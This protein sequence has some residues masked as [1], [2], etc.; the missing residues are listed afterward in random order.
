[1]ETKQRG[2]MF[3]RRRNVPKAR[4]QTGPQTAFLKSKA[5]LTIYGGAAGGGKTYALLMEPLKH[6]HNPDFGAVVFR[7]TYPQIMEEGGLWDEATGMYPAEGATPLKGSV[8]WKFPTGATIRFRHIQYDKDVNTYQGAQI[9]LML[10]DQLEQ[11]S[12][13]QFFAMAAR[14]RSM[15]GV[16]SYQRATCNPQPGW[17]A[18]FVDWWIGDDGYARA[19]RA[20]TLRYYIR[21]ANMVQWGNTIDEVIDKNKDFFSLLKPP[22]HQYINSVT[23]IPATVYDNKILLE[24]DPAYLAKLMG[25]PLIERERLLGGNWKIKE[26]AGKIFNRAWYEIVTAYPHG[27]RACRFWDFAATLKK[28]KGHNPDY[29]ASVLTLKNQEGWFGLDCTNQRTTTVDKLVL[30]LARQDKL[31]LNAQGIQYIVRWEIEPGSASRRESARLTKLLAGFDAKGISSTGDKVQRAKPVS[32]Q[33]EAGNYK[34]VEGKWNEI[35]LA[36]HHGFPDL[37]HDDIVDADSGSFNSLESMG[38][39]ARY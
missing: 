22:Y 12:S 2:M 24:R 3:P 27:G 7:R 35:F 9:G 34:L 19:D 1:M 6:V 10:W 21:T 4:P 11:F 29:T 38:W 37:D 25:L 15:S 31:R 26:E 20:A 13:K 14:N 39:A 16:P 17:L 32:A 18:E 30:N 28:S 33:A 36:Q 5:D 8:S 23:F